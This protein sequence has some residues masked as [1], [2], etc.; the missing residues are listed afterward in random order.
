VDES[1]REFVETW[2]AMGAIWGI[3][4]SVARVHALLLASERAFTL[5][6]IASELQ[7]AKSNASTCLKELRAWRVVRKLTVPGER[8][9]RFASEKDPW[10]M[11]FN[12]ARERKRREF[13]PALQAVRGTLAKAGSKPG[14][15]A[16]ERLRQLEG[17]F[18]TMDA[19][20]NK[21][22]DNETTARLLLGFLAGR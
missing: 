21:A 13:D 9:E 3:N 4:S 1:V 14:G 18:S 19:I 16:I 6:E 22:L 12:I 8:K 2:G 15:V 5:E 11:L 7:I 10:T 20:A 17:M